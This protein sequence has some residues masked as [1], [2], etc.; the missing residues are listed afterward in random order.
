[1]RSRSRVGK[2][3]SYDSRFPSEPSGPFTSW[4]A[5]INDRVSGDSV[6]FNP[7]F[8]VSTI[9][10]FTGNLVSHPS[11]RIY[12]EDMCRADIAML[13]LESFFANVIPD[14]P[15]KVSFNRNDDFELLSFIGELDDTLA[16][17]TKKFY[18]ELSYG[19][20][21]WGLLPF[22]SDVKSLY[23]TG[24]DYV[25]GKQAS[26][27]HKIT[28]SDQSRTHRYE[29][30]HY[31]QFGRRYSVDGVLCYHGSFSRVGV[32]NDRLD[33][34][35]IFLDEL[36]VH[37]DL[38]TVWNL[39]PLSFILDYFVPV[40]DFIESLHPRGWFEPEFRFNGYVS[41]KGTM[42]L[43]R[44]P[45]GAYQPYYSTSYDV[46]CRDVLGTIIGIRKPVPLP[47]FE[48]PDAKQLFNLAYVDGGRSG[49]NARRIS[50]P[51]IRR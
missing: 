14:I 13:S 5:I 16:I 28:S 48:A 33:A 11:F 41:F 43:H 36:G 8:H 21:N 9:A 30:S 35:S 19:S 46:Y 38:A 18:K 51:N 24:S 49:R 27:L 7:C 45:I 3:Y 6:T 34:L 2:Y 25:N 10:P 22:V 17:F 4:I 15:L 31:D 29:G 40:G 23:S 42:V 44:D 1:M 39:V 12:T 47:S 37:P 32:V 50:G 20:V 26:E